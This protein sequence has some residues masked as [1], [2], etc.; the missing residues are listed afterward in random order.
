MEAQTTYRGKYH[1]LLKVMLFTF[2]LFGTRSFSQY[3]LYRPSVVFSDNWEVDHWKE[4]TKIINTYDSHNFLTIMLSQK[5]IGTTY[6]DEFRYL[7][8]NNVNGLPTESIWQKRESNNWVNY[9]RILSTYDGGGRITQSTSQSWTNNAWVNAGRTTNTYNGAGKLLTSV[10][11]QWFDFGTGADWQTFIKFT[12][13]YDGNGYL[14]T[15]LTQTRDFTNPIQ[16]VLVN[17]SLITYANNANGTVN[18]AVTQT[19]VSNAWQNSKK[20]IFTYS[21]TKILT[22]TTQT[23]TNGNWVNT[24]LTTSTYV[25]NNLVKSLDQVWVVASSSWKNDS[26]TLITNNGSGFPTEIINQDWND[27]QS[28]WV[29]VSR[30]RLVYGPLGLNDF[31]STNFAVYP[32]PAY[33]VINIK[34]NE[35][36]QGSDFTIFDETGRVFK[37]GTLHSEETSLNI[38]HLASGVYFFQVG[39]NKLQTVKI[40]KR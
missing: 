25:G 30:V 12:E 34:A 39:Q 1:F 16:V 18:T 20:E 21:G 5:F 27:L 28:V 14:S 10:I 8:T 23:W 11:D 22:E 4:D 17:S 7:Y 24:D 19:W 37:N 2:L 40:I 33:D 15:S 38:N 9:L 6:T 26:Q 36:L 3:E 32:V 13:T 31:V 29:N 35:Q